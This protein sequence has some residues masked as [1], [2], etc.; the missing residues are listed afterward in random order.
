MSSKH[1]TLPAADHDIDTVTAFPTT[2]Q[3]DVAEFE[4]QEW[5]FA[6]TGTAGI[7]EISFDGVN[8]NYRL[9]VSSDSSSITVPCTNRKAWFRRQAAGAGTCRVQA[10]AQQVR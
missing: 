8:V 4:P 6:H 5:S 9:Q 10:L 3:V 2:P 7:V 1:L